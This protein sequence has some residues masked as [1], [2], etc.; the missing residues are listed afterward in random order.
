MN[1]PVLNLLRFWRVLGPGSYH[2]QYTRRGRE[3]YRVVNV[4][5]SE[6]PAAKRREE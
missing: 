3:S 2:F 5:I 1:S 4:A 6:S